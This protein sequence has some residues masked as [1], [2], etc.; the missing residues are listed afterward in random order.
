LKELSR[1]QIDEKYYQ[2][3][4]RSVNNHLHGNAEDLDVTLLLNPAFSARGG[5]SA[6][7]TDAIE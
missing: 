1:D 7:T 2:W 4:G 5:V 6:I 3:G